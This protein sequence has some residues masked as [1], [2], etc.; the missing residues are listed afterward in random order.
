MVDDAA[1]RDTDRVDPHL[2]RTFVT[3]VRRGSFSAAAREL[4]YTQSAVSQQIA[5]LEDELGTPLLSRRPVAPTPAGARLLEHAGPILLRL[6]AARADVARVAGDQ[7]G[8]LVLGASALAVTRQVADALTGLR[9]R[10]PR[11]DLT[12]RVTGREA[13][14]TGVASG[15]ATGGFD[16]GLVDGV[17][18]PSDPLRLWDVGVLTAVGV[19]ARPLVVVLPA[20]HPLAGRPGLHL[21]DLMDARWLDAPDVAAPVAGL[22]AAAEV[23]GPRA[24]VRYQGTDAGGLLALVAAGHGLAVLPADVPLPADVVA[25][26]LRSPR[27]VNRTELLHGHLASDPARWLATALSAT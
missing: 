21:A 18:A 8:R 25:V 27:L 15:P 23:D 3:V 22:R 14:A 17:A 13:V 24:L 11:L 4:R 10:F 7:P 19:A 12:I 9:R 20:D 26:P 6:D 1:I 5:A 16:L 2:L